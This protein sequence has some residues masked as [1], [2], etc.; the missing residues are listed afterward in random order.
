MENSCVC[1]FTSRLEAEKARLHFEKFGCNDSV[2]AV[3]YDEL[4]GQIT[5]CAGALIDM[6]SYGLEIKKKEFEEIKRWRTVKG[7]IAVNLKK[8]EEND[9]TPETEKKN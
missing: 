8:K 9:N 2:V 5:D 1:V 7:R 4:A 3:T 6:S